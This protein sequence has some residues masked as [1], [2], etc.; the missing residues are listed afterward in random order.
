MSE[1]KVTTNDPVPVLDTPVLYRCPRCGYTD[2]ER[3]GRVAGVS[4]HV[5]K[6]LNPDL[7]DVTNIC[8]HCWFRWMREQGWTM[9]KVE[10][11]DG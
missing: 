3:V 9:V 4:L 5:D 11:S 6:D 1:N 2:E 10:D 8:P 7:H